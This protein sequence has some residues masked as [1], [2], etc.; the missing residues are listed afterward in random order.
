MNL[1]TFC[2]LMDN[3]VSTYHFQQ[4]CELSESQKAMKS[5]GTNTI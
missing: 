1:H 5:Y 3:M 4:M 2:D